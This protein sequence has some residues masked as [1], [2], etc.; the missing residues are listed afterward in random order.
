MS[1]TAT[2]VLFDDVV[3]TIIQ[4]IIAMMAKALRQLKLD[5]R[6]GYTGPF[7]KKNEDIYRAELKVRYAFLQKD[8]V[9]FQSTANGLEKMYRD[10][11]DEIMNDHQS[12]QLNI[13]DHQG[14]YYEGDKSDENARQAGD[15][16]KVNFQRLKELQYYAD[17]LF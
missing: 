17:L 16:A 9:K 14:V 1:T 10:V 5:K 7:V 4:P 8:M 15:W 6:D 12:V 13:L 11:L 2:N 3:R